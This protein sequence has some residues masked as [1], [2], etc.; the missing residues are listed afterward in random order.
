[1]LRHLAG[2]AKEMGIKA[3]YAEVL[4]GNTGMLKVFKRSGFPIKLEYE[5]DVTHVTLDIGSPKLSLS[6]P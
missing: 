4:S 2:I 6:N 3:F 5:S 1:M